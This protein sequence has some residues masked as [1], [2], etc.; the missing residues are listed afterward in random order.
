MAIRWKPYPIRH[1]D[2]SISVDFLPVA[3]DLADWLELGRRPKDSP[4]RPTRDVTS[5]YGDDP[6][7]A[8]RS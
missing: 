2:G 1:R 5:Q 8:G 7:D 4:T 3:D 6:T